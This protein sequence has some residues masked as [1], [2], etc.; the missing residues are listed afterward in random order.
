[1]ILGPT[2]R[3]EREKV[4]NA[5]REIFAVEVEIGESTMM[6]E[7]ICRVAIEMEKVAIEMEKV[8]PGG[9]I[10]PVAIEMEKVEKVEPERQ[11]CPVQLEIGE[12]GAV[13]IVMARLVELPI[14]P[15]AQA[16]FLLFLVDI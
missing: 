8:E 3:I 11:I 12:L 1:M 2:Y 7:T 6:I 5:G 15:T 4:E 9:Q 10:Y 14:H 16:T 13:E